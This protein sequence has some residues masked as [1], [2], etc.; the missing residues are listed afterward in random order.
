[1]IIPPSDVLM[2]SS[3][4]ASIDL[5]NNSIDS[6]V[7]HDNP[8]ANAGLQMF[9]EKSGAIDVRS[10][11]FAVPLTGRSEKWQLA[12]YAFSDSRVSFPESGH[13]F[14]CNQIIQRTQ[15]PITLDPDWFDLSSANCTCS[16]DFW[17][18][19]GNCQECS[20]FH[21][22][23]NCSGTFAFFPADFFPAWDVEN[24]FVGL[25]K[26]LTWWN[27]SAHEHKSACKGAFCDFFFICCLFK[28]ILCR[29]LS[30]V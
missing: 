28:D 13:H 29:G 21:G 12:P 26:C 16:P 18:L 22:L 14:L 10:Q 24:N 8:R 30:H 3:F 1:M 2:F 6:R 17:G 27:S 5:V 23:F 15:F 4:P 9:P 25:D 11:S 19:P 7:Q 20:S